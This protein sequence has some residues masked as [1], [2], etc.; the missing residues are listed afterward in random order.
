MSLRRHILGQLPEISP[1][2]LLRQLA[3]VQEDYYCAEHHAVRKD[4]AVWVKGEKLPRCGEDGHRMTFGGN[5]PVATRRRPWRAVRE[6]RL[7]RQ[8]R[9]GYART[10]AHRAGSV[11]PPPDTE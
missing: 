7:R 9:R 2:E 11:V 8:V 1:A 5:M 4:L 3:L 10:T 6:L